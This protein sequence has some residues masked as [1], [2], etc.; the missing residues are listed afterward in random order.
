M[1]RAIRPSASSVTMASTSAKLT[2]AHSPP[3]RW[4]TATRSGK[5]SA[6]RRR[7]EVRGRNCRS[8]CMSASIRATP[9]LHIEART[10]TRL[11]A[12]TDVNFAAARNDDPIRATVLI[13]DDHAGFRTWAA[14]VL[15][16]EGY[17]VI[18]EAGDGRSA[19]ASADALRP[20]IVLLDVQLPDVDGF[21][22]ARRL[23]TSAA[24]V[25]LTSTRDG[26]D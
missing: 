23:R 4:R 1:P 20:D 3:A 10:E 15:R 26:L 14:A 22:V 18:G 7:S 13:V 6:V 12:C 19:V 25:V 17:D 5:R 2:S 24:A 16:G 11:S 9:A 21:E 8:V